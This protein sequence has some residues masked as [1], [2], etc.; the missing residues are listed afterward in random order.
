MKTLT[1]RQYEE[2]ILEAKKQGMEEAA[3]KC[4]EEREQERFHEHIVKEMEEMRRGFHML[5]AGLESKITMIAGEC[6][7]EFKEDNGPKC[8][9]F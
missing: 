2:A 9:P 3:R 8:S 1:D 4:Y 6:G 5:I 7:I